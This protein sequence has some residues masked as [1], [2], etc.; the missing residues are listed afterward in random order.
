VGVSSPINVDSVFSPDYRGNM[1]KQFEQSWQSS[2]P[3]RV[4]LLLIVAAFLAAPTTLCAQSPYQLDREREWLL[5]VSGSALEIGGLVAHN[6]VKPLTL[7]E[8]SA[9]KAS[10]VNSFDRGAIR[11]YR[12]ATAS[13]V[14]V[15]ASI[16]LPLTLLADDQIRRD[17]KVVGVM[18][19]ETLLLE[20]GLNNLVKGLSRRTRPYVYDQQTPLS[21]KANP[22]ARA[23]FY[24]GHTSAAAAMSFFTGRVFSDYLSDRKT[25]ICLWSAAASYPVVV[26]ILRVES[27]KHF[28]SDVIV[29]Y[30]AGAAIGYVIPELHKA[31][32][33]KRISLEPSHINGGPT[34]KLA[35]RF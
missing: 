23:S 22:D 17:W 2:D 14:L 16:V 10:D 5:L 24:S 11:S 19:G 35:Y 4:T 7:D 28:P 21:R 1:R 12:K 6:N 27:G 33:S 15:G 9:L 3:I 32:R 30:V 34:V 31:G 25:R 20:T 29:G 18:W 13:D 26:A 8:I